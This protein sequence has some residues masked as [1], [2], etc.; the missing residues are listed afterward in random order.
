VTLVKHLA[1]HPAVTR[2]TICACF[3]YAHKGRWWHRS[4]I[5]LARLYL[6]S[7]KPRGQGDAYYTPPAPIRSPPSRH[8]HLTF[9]H[10]MTL[11]S[12]ASQDSMQHQSRLGC[13]SS[14][15]LPIFPLPTYLPCVLVWARRCYTALCWCSRFQPD[16]C[17]PRTRRAERG[18]GGEHS[19]PIP[20]PFL[21]WSL[22]NS[23]VH[24]GIRDVS[25][26]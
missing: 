7:E 24:W 12:C 19:M 11:R 15:T 4:I 6:G 26:L 16:V 14:V 22:Q 21:F 13:P 3:V 18:A 1:R 17:Y 23:I 10:Q 8:A 5:L 9:P 20:I 2:L 25:L